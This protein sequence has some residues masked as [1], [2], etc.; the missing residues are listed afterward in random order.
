M[1]GYRLCNVAGEVFV[2]RRRE[3]FWQQGDAL[4]DGSARRRWSM[5][6]GHSES[7]ILDDNL[8]TGADVSQQGGEI[9]R[10]LGCRD[11]SRSHVMM[12]PPFLPGLSFFVSSAWSAKVLGCYSHQTSG[13]S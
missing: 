11:V 7:T 2:N 3:V 13:T 10:G 1:T 6:H 12:I 9:A 4:L 5:Q 8:S